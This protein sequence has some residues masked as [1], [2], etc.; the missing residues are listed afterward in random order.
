[1]A[2]V[3]LSAIPLNLSIEGVQGLVPVDV[4]HAADNFSS[5]SRFKRDASHEQDA[6]LVDLRCL[7]QEEAKL[8]SCNVA[9]PAMKLSGNET[10]ALMQVVAEWWSDE[11]SQPK[12]WAVVEL[13]GGQ[14]LL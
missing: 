4:T 14:K 10:E 6:S 11:L 8:Q 1:M 3:D 9:C 13:T 5:T 12:S 7:G 2:N